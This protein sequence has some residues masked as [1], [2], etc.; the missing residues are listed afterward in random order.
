MTSSVVKCANCNIVISELLAFVQNKA[1]VMD[2]ESIIRLCTT[3][4][5]ED[6]IQQAK[7]LLFEAVGTTRRLITRKK[8]GKSV[9]NME[10]ILMIIKEID[11]DKLPIY[12]ARELHKLP[13]VTF[14][15]IDATSLLKDIVILQ[16]DVASIKANYVKKEMI[17]SSL[18]RS[19][20][21]KN[22]NLRRGACLL[23]SFKYDSGP[24]GLP[25]IPSELY[26]DIE[27]N[28]SSND[29]KNIGNSTIN[30]SLK[31]CI[32]ICN[33]TVVSNSS[34]PFQ[35][36]SARKSAG[37]VERGG[38][39]SETGSQR[40][41][42]GVT[43][44]ATAAVVGRVGAAAGTSSP[45]TSSATSTPTRKDT[46]MPAR[47]HTLNGSATSPLTDVDCDVTN[48]SAAPTRERKQIADVLRQS[49]GTWKPEKPK[50]SWVLVQKKRL[51]NKFIGMKG[52][53]DIGSD[54]TF[55]AAQ[56]QVPFYIY[57][58][59][60]DSPIA[61]ITNYIKRKTD[62]SVKLQKIEMKLV[63]EYVGYKFFIPKDKLAVFMDENLWPS[64]VSF[65]RFVSFNKT[66]GSKQA[67]PKKESNLKDK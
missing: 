21:Y 43:T 37:V 53:A 20:E 48:E 38:R 62:V 27:Q 33:D 34:L 67:R 8:K 31:S 50:E 42:A 52:K 59:D 28:K 7:K 12:V 49:T 66:Q 5:T 6:E 58:I 46:D 26:R 13:P 18:D 15:H 40:R 32:D 2:N 54:C 23:N 61:D 25:H 44:A 11:P 16:N 3:T 10:D 65:R 14:D 22:V 9:R 1:D 17:N 4:F 47:A 64:G 56:I 30:T 57:N 41:A 60:K 51:K 63:R 24:I 45:Q 35:N 19:D 29:V 39:S 55:K 36:K